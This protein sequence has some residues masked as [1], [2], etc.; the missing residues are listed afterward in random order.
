MRH[1]R[2]LGM[3]ALVA[4][5][6]TADAPHATAQAASDSTALVA[7]MW[8]AQTEARSIRLAWDHVPGA[9]S[10]AVWCTIGGRRDK[11]MGTVGA[12]NTVAKD[13]AAPPIRLFSTVMVNEPD[14]PH[15][16]S[17]QWSRDA[18][19]GL[20]LRAAF[21]EVVPIVPGSATKI[22]PPSV[23]ARATGVG[24]ITLTWS[25]VPGATA[26]I[27]GR[28][29]EPEGYRMRCDICSTSTTFV[30]RYAKAG[31]AHSY[32]VTA[33]TPAGLS[34]RGTSNRIVALGTASAVAAQSDAAVSPTLR[35]PSS[36]TAA[37]SGATTALVTWSNVRGAPA[38]QVLR[39]LNGGSLT[40]VAR[41]QAGISDPVEYS[42]YLGGV[43]GT[44]A[45]YAVKALDSAANAT[46]A[47]MSNE[48]TLQAKAETPTGTSPTQPTSLRAAFSG[49][50]AV[51]LTWRPPGNAI[52]CAVRR[53]TGGSGSYL[54]LRAFATGASQYFDT[55]PGLAGMRPQYQLACG[56]PKSATIVS[57]PNPI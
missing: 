38:Y 50:D 46:T 18:K 22:A 53:R 12:P 15:R 57:F 36:V 31:A 26:Y 10:Y 37:V 1:S 40:L 34:V 6:L 39:S 42:D 29:V 14:T 54:T 7:S 30:D 41:V 44:R 13:A 8:A 51:T 28:A 4:I 47:T 25:A 45:L 55:A 23:T 9:T 17:L 56:D 2:P 48:I 24:E 5:C 21:N 35:A 11:G 49:A 3:F 32:A 27:V 52:P 20:P 33:V 43:S 16:C 19:T